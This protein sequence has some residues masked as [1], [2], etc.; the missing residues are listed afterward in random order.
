MRQHKTLLTTV[1]LALAALLP[2][3][4]GAQAPTHVRMDAS[5]HGTTVT[6]PVGGSL[7]I[8]DDDSQ[9]PG[10][11]TSGH[12]AAGCDYTLTIGGPC[13]G[14]TLLGL[15]INM[16][17]ISCIDTLYIYDG[18][19]TTAPVRARIN[20]A[21]GYAVGDYILAGPANPSGRLTLR[22]RTHPRTYPEELPSA[23]L[24]T[25]LGF[26]LEALCRHPC[27]N[28]IP[29]IDSMF[30]RMRDGKVYDTVFMALV[31]VYD[32]TRGDP[33]LG[34]PD[35][36]MHID[37]NWFM[38]ANLCLGDGIALRAHVDY[39]HFRGPDDNSTFFTWDMDNEGDS[40]RGLGLNEITYDEYRRL[41][42]HDLVLSIV[43]EYGCH[44]TRTAS[45]RVRT[46]GNPIKTLFTL[47][48]ICNRDSL[49][50]DMGYD[51]DNATLT[52]RHIRPDSVSTKYNNVRVF[53]P[54]GGTSVSSGC[55]TSY[56]EAPVEFNEFPNQ[57]RL[58]KGEEIC[59]ICIN[60]EHSYMGDIALSI[61]CPSGQEAFLKYGYYTAGR[62]SGPGSE[63][64]NGTYLGFPIEDGIWDND[65]TCDSTVNPYGIGL[66]YCF[67]RNKDYTL[68]TGQPANFA[69]DQRPAGNFY[70]GS[71]AYT[72]TQSVTFP[73]V[74]SGFSQAGQTP[75]A[76]S[77][78][79][80]MPSNYADSAG[81]YLPYTNFSELIGC[82]LNGVWKLRVYDDWGYDNGWVFGWTMDICNHS[83][84]SYE[85][86]IDSLVWFPDPSPRYH[87]YD[88]G[89]YRGLVSH[90][91]DSSSAYLLS[92]DTAGSFPIKVLIY[93]EFGCLW[94]TSTAINTIWTPQPSLGPDTALC[95]D[96]QL[97]LDATD[98]HT[99]DNKYS[100][101]WHPDGSES[102][103]LTTP[104][105]PA[106][107]ATYVVQVT[108]TYRHSHCTSRDT[109][110]VHRLR[111]PLPSFSPLPSELEG[112][113][114]FTIHFE[115]QTP[116]AASHLWDFGDGIQ[117]TLPSP[118]HTYSS[119]RYSL[120]YYATS[121]DGCTD[122]VIA[123]QAVTVFPTPEAAFSWNPVYPSVTQPVVNLLNR[124][125]PD[126]PDNIYRWELQYN[127][128][129]P[130]SY[131]TLTS[132]DATFNYADYNDGSHLAGSYNVH[133]I[134]RTDN[135]A[136]SG[137]TVQCSDTARNTILVLNDFLQFPNVVT[138]N[139]DGV[140]DRFVIIGLL[141]GGAYPVNSLDVY[142]SWGVPVYHRENLASP[143]D[144]WDP[145]DL[146]TGTYYY[147]FSARGPIGSVE[148]S[149][150]VEVLAE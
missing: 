99:A 63:T 43:D 27:I 144:F 133:L 112:C 79:T 48:D 97:T 121:P 86:G 122:S 58:T 89:H 83:D 106:D 102:P 100:Y 74:A 31:P 104:L 47:P 10:A 107:D 29:V 25:G 108:N 20:N 139:D 70:L 117:S 9:G 13:T 95:G 146:P 45:V 65:P 32:T 101:L 71:S 81:Y 75:P 49:L 26:T 4:V 105:D 103:T 82:P 88:L 34:E 114:P 54:D 67:S 38:G 134:A 64:G 98:A 17:D 87:D 77:I 140:N 12:Y 66:E 33:C 62:P 85:V 73:P 16:L 5:T 40:L 143:D 78:T 149:G 127:A 90:P 72:I 91:V 136:P 93:D 147:R 119:G 120:R 84:C 22:F 116:E 92:P 8:S 141:E 76:R 135:L 51:G 150:V 52:L 41:S 56:Y 39:G 50:V 138:P 130:L 126:S 129:N 94:D 7:T 60:I 6:Y 2:T 132:H 11:P 110:Q 28:A 57:R 19:D 118:V 30:Y 46:S 36:I 69:C 3:G 131:H 142:N 42:C 148:H 109:I 18:A 35:T 137:R 115:N 124:T 55:P 125:R 61:V 21:T 128:A 53:I 59:S 68:V 14:D 1:F 80:K 111:Q 24:E 145:K 23:C 15:K 123:P 113:E 44:S 96:S 37:T